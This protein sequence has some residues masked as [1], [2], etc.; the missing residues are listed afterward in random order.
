M[1][2]HRRPLILS[3]LAHD[4][5]ASAARWALRASGIDAVWAAALG[6]AET[7]PMS[8]HCDADTG[9]HMSGALDDAS[10]G[11]V[12]YRRARNPESF[13]RAHQ[14]D[15]AF[16]RGEWGRFLKNVYALT[17]QG[18]DRLWVNR[19]NAAA[20]AENKLVQLRAAHRCG[21]RFPAT[22][23]SHD[24]AEIRRFV[25]RHGRVVYKPFMTHTWK[26]AESGRMFSTYARIVE[27]SMLD[28]DDS[29]LHC[30]GIYQVYVDKRY[31]LRVTAIGDR[32]LAAR[33]YCEHDDGVVDWRARQAVQGLRA[34]AGELSAA[35]QA[36]LAALMRELGLV[37][38]CIDL[39]IDANGD[40]HFLEIN[41]AGQFLFVED[42]VPSL[43]LLRAMSAMLAEGRADY[44]LATIAEVSY[45]DYCASE[46]HRAWWAQASEGLQGRGPAAA[47]ISLE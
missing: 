47:G 2:A 27:A 31:D 38:G 15:Q 12:W 34:Q 46:E 32:Y 37:F 19:P 43:P 25:Q 40:A 8:L 29:L 22:L 21:L 10:I 26:D 20:M 44:S 7:G 13:P 17:D 39:A 45:A 35:D 18:A 23:V 42:L 5:H 24:P 30:P 14:S 1:P 9:L 41:Q 6:Q 33:L 36:K 3:S 28:D 11:T 16:L 4:I